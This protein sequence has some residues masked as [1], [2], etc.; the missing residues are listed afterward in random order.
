MDHKFNCDD[1]S[2][3]YSSDDAIEDLEKVREILR[4]AK[5]QINKDKLKKSDID[6]SINIDL[7]NKN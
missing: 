7:N 1:D 5:M 4:D 6:V 2:K 3:P